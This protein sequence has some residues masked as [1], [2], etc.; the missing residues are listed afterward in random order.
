LLAPTP[1]QARHL[2]SPYS[3]ASAFTQPLQSLLSRFSP[4]SSRASHARR[5]T[6]LV[7]D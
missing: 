1:M 2:F 3:A 4:Y 5:V 7:A 6:A